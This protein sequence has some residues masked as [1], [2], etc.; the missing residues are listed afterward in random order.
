MEQKH[1]LAGVLLE[2]YSANPKTHVPV[3]CSHSGC[4][5]YIWT[6]IGHVSGCIS[7]GM[8]G[9][10]NTAKLTHAISLMYAVFC[11]RIQAV[12]YICINVSPLHFKAKCLRKEI[13]YKALNMG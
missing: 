11:S 4:L 2:F 1:F 10:Q 5:S 6:Y 13:L 8:V 9:G 7:E 3:V 12:I